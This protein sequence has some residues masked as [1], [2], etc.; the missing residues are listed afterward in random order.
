[1]PHEDIVL[2]DR[3]KHEV[4]AQDD[5]LRVLVEF[6]STGKDLFVWLG[7]KHRGRSDHTFAEIVINGAAGPYIMPRFIGLL[8]AAIE[9]KHRIV[10]GHNE[11]KGTE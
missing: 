9:E 10:S 1:M 7:S 8:Q 4:V 3:I 11:S 2:T 6:D 5:N